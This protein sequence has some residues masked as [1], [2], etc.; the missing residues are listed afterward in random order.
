[1]A[2]SENALPKAVA[3][4]SL[5]KRLREGLS[6]LFASRVGVVG[7]IIVLFW[8]FVAIFAPLLTPYSPTEQDYTAQNQPPSRA[9]ILGTDSLGRDIW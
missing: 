3:R 6:V 9:H 7:L 1:M 8:V 4:P 5:W 2:V